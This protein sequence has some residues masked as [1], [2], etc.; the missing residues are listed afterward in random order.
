[1][2][3]KTKVSIDPA[4]GMPVVPED[5][6]WEVSADFGYR[7]KVTLYRP[8]APYEGGPKVEPPIMVAQSWTSD[9]TRA[10]VREAAV[11]AVREWHDSEARDA[12]NAKLAGRYPP[13]RLAD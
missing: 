11:S 13:M 3:K 7:L 12:A 4:T 5:H 2:T 9:N 8:G 10:D 1:M 6:W